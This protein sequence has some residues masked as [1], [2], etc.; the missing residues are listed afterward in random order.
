MTRVVDLYC[1]WAGRPRGCYPRAA[2]L[3]RGHLLP[4][5]RYS[6]TCSLFA[7]P[8]LPC[9]VVVEIGKVRSNLFQINGGVKEPLNLPEPSGETV[10]LSEK[11]YVPVKEHP[12]F[13]FVGRILGPRGMT[14]KQLE[15]ETCCKIMVRGKGS[16]R[17]KFKEDQNR[18]KPNWEHLNDDLHVLITVEDTENRAK[19]KLQRA[20][21]EIKKLLV[22]SVGNDGEDELKKR[23]L[24][25]LAIINGTYRDSSTRGI[26][27]PQGSHSLLSEMLPRWDNFEALGALS[28]DLPR[29]LASGAL[30][31]SP[32]RAGT[33]LTG[34]PLIMPAR[35]PIPNSNPQLLNG[36]NMPPPPM[37]M[38]PPLV[39]VSEAG[40]GLIYASPYVP[41]SA[42]EYTALTSPMLQ[43]YH[44]DPNESQTSNHHLHHLS[45]SQ[46]LA[47]YQTF[48]NSTQ[49]LAHQLDGDHS[50][51]LRSYSSAYQINQLSNFPNASPYQILALPNLGSVAVAPSHLCLRQPHTRGVNTR[52]ASPS[53]FIIAPHYFLR[54]SNV[55]PQV[56]GVTHLPQSG[57]T[58]AAVVSSNLTPPSVSESHFDSRVATTSSTGL[59][60][61]PAATETVDNKCE[62]SGAENVAFIVTAAT[63]ETASTVPQK[64][65]KNL[66]DV[67]NSSNIS[68][69]AA[70]DESV[71]HKPLPSSL[72]EVSVSSEGSLPCK[73]NDSNLNSG[74]VSV[75]SPM[76]SSAY[77]A[78]C[79]NTFQN[80][81]SPIHPQS[82][83][84]SVSKKPAHVNQEVL[85]TNYDANEDNAR[86]EP[87][88]KSVNECTVPSNSSD[89]K[90]STSSL[91]DV[92][93]QNNSDPVSDGA[94]L[95]TLPPPPPT[96]TSAPTLLNNS[97][98]TSEAIH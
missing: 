47:G 66:V 52:L 55:Y 73:S 5:P 75:N 82:D 37:G 92:V 78:V 3:S 11:V 9:H 79:S 68:P 7:C 60:V 12:D 29:L 25:E 56:V 26:V 77:A 80:N 22:P 34:H 86:I 74:C 43:E 27:M 48:F 97:A 62:S 10:S 17:D 84:P 4:C 36:T 40:G 45:S 19:I 39:P 71:T 32:L 14:A 88:S 28:G 16:M 57:H 20:T 6:P 33:P 42:A 90:I 83:K 46:Q 35:I 64:D 85:A 91:S 51:S 89:P 21:D 30:I 67:C 41:V 72:L 15:Q 18:G 96:T 50:L 81:D 98:T 59:E 69:T 38:M 2:S 61:V 63:V 44:H 31:P 1:A 24:M 49:N 8:L 76:C 95:L 53:S 54:P 23:Q 94:L 58:S 65:A 93:V 87:E 70:V 13:N